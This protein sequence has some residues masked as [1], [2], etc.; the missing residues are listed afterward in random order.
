MSIIAYVLG[1]TP[2]QISALR[3]NPSLAGDVAR[4]D[5]YDETLARR[6]ELLSRLPPERRKQA[7][8]RQAE[9]EADA[10]Q[11]EHRARI[12]Q[13][14]ERIAPIAPIERAVCLEKSW[15][16]LHYLL[17]GHIGPASAPGDLLLT[18]QDLGEDVGYGPARLHDPMET[19]SFGQFLETQDLS[20]LQRR[21]NFKE[22]TQ[23]HLYGVPFGRGSESEF[24]TE[25]RNEVGLY[26]PLLRDYVRGMSDRANGLLLWNS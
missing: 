22:M 14:R 6:G 5:Q 1:I 13:A 25:L 26:F 19:R 15:H 10:A 11:Q 21:V 12:S 2:A 7:E 4:T 17:T 16:I 23:L 18:G 20:S 24:E 8:A 3:A 9:F